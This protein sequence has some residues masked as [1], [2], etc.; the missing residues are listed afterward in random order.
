MVRRHNTRV[1]KSQQHIMSLVQKGRLEEALSMV[2]K[3][4][5]AEPHNSD[6][7]LL[8]GSIYANLNDF[9]SVIYCCGKVLDLNPQ[10]PAAQ[11]QP[12]TPAVLRRKGGLCQSTVEIEEVE[13]L[14]DWN[15]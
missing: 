6:L 14:V 13:D 2:K 11:P 7:W 4:A 1:D 10:H 3:Q 9:K 12:P 15:S 8:Q 5:R